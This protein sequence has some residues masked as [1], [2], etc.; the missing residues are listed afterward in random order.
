M[1]DSG[2]LEEEQLDV[3][4]G[5]D[6]VLD[7]A[8]HDAEFARTQPDGAS[9]L[10]DIE[11]SVDDQEKLVLGVMPVPGDFV[12]L[13]PDELDVLPVELGH[14]LGRERVLE[15]AEAPLDIHGFDHG[16]MIEPPR[17][18]VKPPEARRQLKNAP[19]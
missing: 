14:D 13:G 4:D 12:A 15:Q 19:I 5:H 11:N 17:N 2:R 16:T 18:E 8:R 3:A 1:G 9:P 10:A 6:L 7:P